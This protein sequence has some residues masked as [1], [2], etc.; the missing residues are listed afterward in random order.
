A[1]DRLVGY[2]VFN[3]GA[4]ATSTELRSWVTA[5]LPPYMV[6]GF[7]VPL[8]ELSLTPNGKVDRK[9]LPAPVSTEPE[10]V[11]LDEEL[12][13]MER[14]IAEVWSSLLG[15]DRISAG[16]N[17]FEIGGHSLLAVEAVALIEERTGHRPEPRSLFFMTLSELASTIP[18]PASSAMA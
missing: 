18:A 9:Q 2:G 4:A 7:I 13:P 8:E 16:D 6:P 11:E 1:D 15:I 14:V 3:P 17:F 10:P 12:E 5:T